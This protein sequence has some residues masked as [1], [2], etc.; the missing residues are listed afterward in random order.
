MKIYTQLQKGEAHPVFCEDF[1]MVQ[2]DLDGQFLV[3]AV[4]DGC[5]GGKETHFASTFIA[6]SFRNTIFQYNAMTWQEE[7]EEITASNL[8]RDLLHGV[9]EDLQTLKDEFNISTEE[10][11][12]TIILLVYDFKKDFAY[13]VSV[14]DGTIVID[15]EIH[16]IEQQNMPNYLAYHLKTD[17]ALFFDKLP[18]F[19]IQS[20]KNLAISTDGIDSF[21]DKQL[22]ACPIDV[23]KELLVND[24]ENKK[25]ILTSKIQQLYEQHNQTAQDDL[26]IVRVV[27]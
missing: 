17:F 14:G 23:T 13:V 9:A 3:A 25:N 11:V 10:L 12:S 7:D 26:A 15:N 1:L 5:S 2:E 24:L 27:F 18:Y 20:P 4:M 21:F 8:L 16:R 22:Q 19:K 6:K